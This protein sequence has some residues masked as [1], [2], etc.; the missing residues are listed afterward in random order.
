MKIIRQVFWVAQVE[1]RKFLTIKN[2]ILMLFSLIFLG[3]SVVRKMA[4][5]SLET[6]MKLNWLEPMDLIL[7]Y[8]FHAMII[9]IAFIVLLSNFPDKSSGSI[10]MMMRISRNTWLLGQLMYA[11]S[12]GIF[13]LCFLT[14]GNM[15]W[16]GK[17]GVFSMQWSPYM[18]N[19]YTEYPEIY[20]QNMDMFIETGTVAQGKPV[21]IFLISCALMLLYLVTLAQILCLFKLVKW[22]RIGLFFNMALT[23]LGAVSVSYL[24]KVKWIFPLVHS[25]FG[26]HFHTFFAQPEFRLTYSVVYYAVLNF[27]LF[28][29]NRHIAGI[30]HIGDD[31]E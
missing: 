10:F 9:P 7:S 20:A 19:L 29:I 22:K 5:I 30:C 13:Y 28:L 12:V 25:I 15:F 6:G 27:I 26:I 4:E 1:F 16:I 17:T 11:F 21:G 2:L 31:C 18:T 14:V 24:G 3:E 8:S 23:V